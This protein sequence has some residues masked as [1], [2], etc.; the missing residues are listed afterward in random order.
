MGDTG[1]LGGAFTKAALADPAHRL[2]GISSGERGGQSPSYAHW[3][4]DLAARDGSC[5]KV[6]GDFAPELVVNCA[7]L[8]DLAR[9]EREPDLARGLNA[10][11]PER[12]AEFSKGIGASFVHISTDQVFDGSKMTPYTEKDAPAPVNVYGRTKLDA[13]RRVSGVGGRWLVVRTNLV[14]FKGA[15]GAPTFA[16]WLFGAL[17]GKKTIT[18]ADDFVTSPIEVSDLSALILRAAQNGLKGIF[19][20]GSHDACSKYDFGKIVAAKAGLDF[21][22]VKKGKLADL[23]LAPRRPAHLALDV[24]VAEEAVGAL[25]PTAADTAARLVQRYKEENKR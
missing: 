17:A 23:G 6:A 3:R 11:M 8:V 12:W 22:S 21:S 20:I 10:D 25:F 15:A 4:M 13:E 18:L 24:S 2:L 5:E 9:C 14:G 1:L 16:E 19:H 7:A